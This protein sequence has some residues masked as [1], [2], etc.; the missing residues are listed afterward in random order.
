VASQYCAVI[1]R[2]L[3]WRE[4][5]EWLI[6]SDVE[7]EFGL[8]LIRELEIIANSLRF[9]VAPAAVEIHENV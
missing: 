6:G 5:N 4:K 9:C 2:L 8:D 3:E 1:D 7:A